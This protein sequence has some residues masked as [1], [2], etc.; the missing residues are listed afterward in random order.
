MS[1][2][3]VPGALDVWITKSPNVPLLQANESLD[4]EMRSLGSIVAK[5][6]WLLR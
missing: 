6:E 4:E 3:A 1:A 2:S 5:V